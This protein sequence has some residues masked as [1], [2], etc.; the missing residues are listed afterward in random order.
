MARNKMPDQ[1]NGS[2]LL[3]QKL[4]SVDNYLKDPANIDNAP[5][6]VVLHSERGMILAQM[7]RWEESAAS[8]GKV[9]EIAEA[10][11][12]PDVKARGYYLQASSLL[13][14]PDQVDACRHAITQA[15]HNAELTENDDLAGKGRLLLALQHTNVGDLPEASQ[16]LDRA[17]KLI[18]PE[19]DALPAVQALRLRAS[20]SLMQFDLDASSAGLEKALALAKKDRNV[21]L[22]QEI[23]LELAVVGLFF[24]PEEQFQNPEE[25]FG[26]LIKRAAATGN[27]D[28]YGS[29]QL[30]HAVAHIQRGKFESALRHAEEAR[31]EA[32]SAPDI[33]RYIRYFLACILISN[34]RELLDDKPG[35]L[36]ILLTCQ[37]TMSNELSETSAQAM[38]PFFD[39][40]RL[41]WGEE[42]YN[43]VR[44][45][46]QS[47]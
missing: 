21:R 23:E 28:L 31:Q 30:F 36:K 38:E 20:F 4:L 44:R 18:N 22:E 1:D 2:S 32:L 11:D 17:I 34:A 15:I 33:Q 24:S 13:R 46:S 40:L 16:E 41:R 10:G 27:R 43:A 39:F 3:E 5:K 9:I 35:A 47:N 19:V 12:A 7:H 8:F 29:A 42:T 25:L 45:A 14:L 26:D 6:M 37:R